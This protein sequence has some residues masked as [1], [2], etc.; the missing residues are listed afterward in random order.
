MYREGGALWKDNPQEI[1]KNEKVY[2]QKFQS[3]SVFCNSGSSIEKLMEQFER[4]R[5]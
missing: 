2:G 1:S 3:S 5:K 4:D